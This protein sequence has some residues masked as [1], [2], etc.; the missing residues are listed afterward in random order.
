MSKN[1]TTIPNINQSN[2][3]LFK[4]DFVYMEK[5]GKSIIAIVS[6]VYN[7]LYAPPGVC[8]T[9]LLYLKNLIASGGK[10]HYSYHRLNFNQNSEEKNGFNL[11]KGTSD[12]ALAHLVEIASLLTEGSQF[13]FKDTA[14]IY[15]RKLD[16]I[17]AVMKSIKQD[18]NAA[19]IPSWNESSPDTNVYGILGFYH[20]KRI[21]HL[22]AIWTDKLIDNRTSEEDLEMILG[23]PFGFKSI[24]NSDPLKIEYKVFEIP[25]AYLDLIPKPTKFMVTC[26][27]KSGIERQTL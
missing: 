3:E 19:N 23:I 7:G 16:Y 13:R 10:P 24:T 6:D 22:E 17:K 15:A 21:G 26:V 18:G 9:R 1:K 8:F 12:E 2:I 5:N 11:R 25:Q 27:D 4:G 14:P 20:G